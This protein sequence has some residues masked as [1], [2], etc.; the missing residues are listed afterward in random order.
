MN[1][2][3]VTVIKE[4]CRQETFDAIAIY[5]E[6]TL[7]TACNEHSAT[8]NKSFCVELAAFH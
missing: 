7:V 8:T 3:Q 2:P 5:E 4:I 1:I 6:V